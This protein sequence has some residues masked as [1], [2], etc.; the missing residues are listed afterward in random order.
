[1]REPQTWV[2]PNNGDN[3]KNSLVM[4]NKAVLQ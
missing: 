2:G 1:M 4:A 3:R